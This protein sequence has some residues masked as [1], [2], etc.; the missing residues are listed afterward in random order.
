[1]SGR[2]RS[3]TVKKGELGDRF[4][5]KGSAGR[6]RQIVQLVHRVGTRLQSIFYEDMC[7]ER[8]LSAQEFPRFSV[9]CHCKDHGRIATQ[10]DKKHIWLHARSS[11]VTASL[12]HCHEA[13]KVAFQNPDQPCM[14]VKQSTAEANGLTRIETTIGAKIATYIQMLEI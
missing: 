8:M 7:V 6:L 1:M 9:R 4:R 3:L 11:V 2:R 10:S 13:L 5:E 14:R 12:K